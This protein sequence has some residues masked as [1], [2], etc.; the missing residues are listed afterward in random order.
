MDQKKRALIEGQ[1]WLPLV[2]NDQSKYN[3][4]VNPY[5]RGWFG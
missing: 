5:V 4:S 2:G 1:S 3:R